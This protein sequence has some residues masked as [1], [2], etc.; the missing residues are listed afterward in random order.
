MH[1]N[2]HHIDKEIMSFDINVQKHLKK[3]HLY[4]HILQSFDIKHD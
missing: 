3:S 2:N 4:V 1:A